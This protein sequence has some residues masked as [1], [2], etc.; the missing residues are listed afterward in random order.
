MLRFQCN[1]VSTEKKETLCNVIEKYIFYI[2]M[3]CSWFFYGRWLIFFLLTSLGRG[4]SGGS[5]VL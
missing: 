1:D 2:V 5:E 4:W 3:V